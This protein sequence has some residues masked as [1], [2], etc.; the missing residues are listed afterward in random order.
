MREDGASKEKAARIANASAGQGR[1]QVGSKGG[2]SP[3]YEEWTV[4]DLRSRAKELGLSGYSRQK[5]SELIDNL[6]NH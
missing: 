2:S 5:K 6:R 3:S 4:D 1:K